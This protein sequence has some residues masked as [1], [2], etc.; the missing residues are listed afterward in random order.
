MVF[1]TTMTGRSP[2]A[3]PKVITT[4]PDGPLPDEATP[5]RYRVAFPEPG[6]HEFHVLLQVPPLPTRTNVELVFS[7]W[8]P[9][10]YMIRDFVR[11][12]YGLEITDARGR[13][14]PSERL[15]KQRWR[16]ASQGAAFVVRYRVF[17]FEASVRTSFLDDSHAYW[18][19]TSLFFALEGEASRPCEVAVD[20]PAS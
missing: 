11:H 16:V 6:N 9:G 14:L 2:R 3:V 15:D 8:A 4:S 19:G 1:C 17:A 7:A 10:S 18:N 12:V 5:L 13:A 20:A